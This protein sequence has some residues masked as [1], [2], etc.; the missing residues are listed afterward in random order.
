MQFALILLLLFATGCWPAELV[1]AKKRRQRLGIG[2][3][4]PSAN[5]MNDEGF[6][7]HDSTITGLGSEKNDDGSDNDVSMNEVEVELR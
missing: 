7:D 2:D 4:R 1:D 5:N 3:D 6:D